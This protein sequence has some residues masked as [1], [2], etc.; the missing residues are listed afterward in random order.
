MSLHGGEHG[1][2]LPPSVIEEHSLIVNQVRNGLWARSSIAI[3]K[4]VSHMLHTQPTSNS[5]SLS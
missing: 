4:V 5:T 2:A 1:D 3:S